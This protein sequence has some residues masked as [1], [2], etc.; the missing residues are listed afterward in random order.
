MCTVF[1]TARF[2]PLPPPS[3]LDFLIKDSTGKIEI[4]AYKSGIST[5]VSPKKKKMIPVISVSTHAYASASH[6]LSRHDPPRLRRRPFST[7]PFRYILRT[8]TLY[9]SVIPSV[10]PAF[11]VLTQLLHRLSLFS[12]DF[13]RTM[14]ISVDSQCK[15]KKKFLTD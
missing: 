15:K 1:I 5:R 14:I 2:F 8:H 11:Y 4:A 6:H 12:R 9:S 3:S 7:A 10:Q 13:I